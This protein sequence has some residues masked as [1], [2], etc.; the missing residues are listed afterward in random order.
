MFLVEF[1]RT[2]HVGAVAIDYVGSGVDT[3]MGELAQRTAVFTTEHLLAPGQAVLLAAFGS[4]VERDD[5]D[6]ALGYQGGDDLAHGVEVLVA[7]GVAVV[8]KG[9]EPI[10]HAVALYHYPV[11][12]LKQTCVGYA[13]AVQTAACAP[14]AC[15]AEVVG[16]V[17]GH[18]EEIETGLLQ[19]GSEAGRRA[20]G[21]AHGRRLL[22]GRS[23]V[24]QRTLQVACR[25]I[26]PLQQGGGINKQ[27]PSFL[28]RQLH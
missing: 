27:L 13:H 19:Q 3:E 1:D 28:G 15:R 25:H 10:A 20:E 23:A 22:V 8:A 21:I 18:R 5:D 17:V 6:I 2:H 7:Q 4:A 14:D 26:G 16:M 9:A 12:G 11:G 24:T